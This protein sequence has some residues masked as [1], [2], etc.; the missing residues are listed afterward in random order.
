MVRCSCRRDP[1][2]AS[3]GRISCRRT[4][5]L[6]D[7]PRVIY[8]TPTKRVFQ[9]GG[10]LTLRSEVW[11]SPRGEGA[12]RCMVRQLTSPL[13]GETR[14]GVIP[15]LVP[16]QGRLCQS[17]TRA[18][19]G[20]DVLAEPPSPCPSGPF[21]RAKVEYSSNWLGWLLMRREK[22]LRGWRI[23]VVAAPEPS[24]ILW[25]NFGYARYEEFS[26]RSR[27]HVPLISSHHTQPCNPARD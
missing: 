1:Q 23:T 2:P 25:E 22:R 11:M 4:R 6:D 19:T 17:L 26:D 27:S 14:S 8:E 7:I 15:A 18:S 20:L 3:R 10:L 13:P 21:P 24:T 12:I 9:C 5:C 16:G